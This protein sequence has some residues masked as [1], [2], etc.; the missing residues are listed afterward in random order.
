[1]GQLIVVKLELNIQI[2]GEV[3]FKTLLISIN[4]KKS[5]KDSE[6]SILDQ[7]MDIFSD[8]KF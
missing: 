2:I 5:Q 1:M 7:Y 6:I 3:K 8:W 4:L